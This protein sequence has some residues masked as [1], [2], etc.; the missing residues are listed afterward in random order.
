MLSSQHKALLA[1][2][3]LV[4]TGTAIYLYTQN[5]RSH[6]K[7]QAPNEE[8]KIPPKQS[9]MSA[10]FPA[11]IK[12]A[13][14]DVVDFERLCRGDEQESKKLFAAA[15]SNGFFFLRNH[16]VLSESESMYELAKTTFALPLPEKMKFDMGTTGG[17]FGYRYGFVVV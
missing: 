12:P 17:Y 1:V 2:G 9:T 10:R 15:T 7:Q 16:G 14:L 6:E 8:E 13:E 4:G 3:V 5:K 11:S